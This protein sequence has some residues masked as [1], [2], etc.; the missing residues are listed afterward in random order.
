MKANTRALIVSGTALS[1]VL[2]AAVVLALISLAMTLRVAPVQAH[3][4]PEVK[5][6]PNPA[7]FGGEVTIEGEGFE[8]EDKV[9]LILE[10]VLGE[11]ALDTVTTDSE[12][13]FSLTLTLPSSASPGS[14]RIRAVGSDDVAIADLRIVGAAG[15]AAPPPVHEAE[16]NFHGIGAT[17]EVVG[18][19]ALAAVAVLAGVA[20]IWL[21]KEERRA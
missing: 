10:G 3:G 20:L 6:D 4:N 15:G 14:Y 12:G 19:A 7:D 8:G 11:T 18:F 5:V 13:M 9:S 17:T 21:P 2:A 1:A 16:V